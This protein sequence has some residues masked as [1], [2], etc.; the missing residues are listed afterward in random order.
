MNQLTDLLGQLAAK[1]GTTIE[2]LWTVLI[3]QAPIDGVVSIFQYILVIIWTFIAVKY[4]KWFIKGINSG[5]REEDW[6][7]LIVVGWLFTI[8][9]LLA[10]FFSLP[11]TV[12]AFINPQYWALEHVLDKIAAAKK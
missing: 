1:L 9:L 12:A 2:L 4:T 7:I 10:L 3:R 11:D 5:D 8:G 6:W